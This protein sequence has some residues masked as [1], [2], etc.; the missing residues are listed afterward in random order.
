M[1]V[2]QLKKFSTTIVTALMRK[3]TF[4]PL[5]TYEWKKDRENLFFLFSSS[6]FMFKA[7]IKTEADLTFCFE[8]KRLGVKTRKAEIRSTI[9]STYT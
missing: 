2:E 9:D 1:K 3:M 5:E 7:V 6:F 8:H 4:E